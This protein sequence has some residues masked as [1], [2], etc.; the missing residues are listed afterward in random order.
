MNILLSLWR[1]DIFLY[2]CSMVKNNIPFKVAVGYVAVAVVMVMA[3]VLVYG[4][5]QSLLNI[6]KMSRDYN[7]KRNVVDSLVY[8]MLDVSNNER[9]IYM[10]TSKDWKKLR[11][12]IKEAK[13]LTLSLKMLE[14]DSLQRARMDTL[15]SLLSLKQ[16]NLAELRKIMNYDTRENLLNEKMENLNSGKDSVMVHTKT[17]KTH[18]NERTTVEVVKT[19]KGFFRRLADA[20]KKGTTDTISIHNDVNSTTTD[21]VAIPVDVA[22]E[23]VGVLSQINR[24]ERKHSIRKQ[25]AV[26][27]ELG[28]LRIVSQQLAH[29]TTLLLDTIRDNEKRTMQEA[30]VRALKSR[31]SLL[32][33]I[34][35]LALLAIV[36]AGILFLYISRDAKKERIYR[37][38]LENANAEIQRI[39]N[40]R[41]RLLLTI[42]HDIKAPVASISGFIDLMR[43][44]VKD[45][46]AIGYIDN[47]VN[48][49]DHLSRLVASLLDYHKLENGQMELHPTAFSPSA[50]VGQATE[51]MRMLA[52]R[53][54]LSI[55]MSFKD[56][57]AARSESD[58]ASPKHY[59]ADA[60]RIRQVLDN[61]ISNAIKYTQ[62]GEISVNA[63]VSKAPSDGN[64]YLTVSVKDTGMGMTAEESRRAFMAFTRLQNAQGIEGTGLGL[65]ITHELVTLLG[66]K[67]TLKSVKDVGSTFTVTIPVSQATADDNAISGEKA[68]DQAA[69]APFQHS[70]PLTL[71]NQKILILDDDRLQLQLL[72]E[73]LRSKTESGWQVFACQHVTDALTILHNEKPALMLMDIE[74][75]EMS[76]MEIIRMINHSQMK[77]VAMTAHDPSIKAELAKAGFDGCL[78]KPFQP[79]ALESL[80]GPSSAESPQQSCPSAASEHS[81]VYLSELLA[82]A[83]GDKEAEQEILRTVIAE[84]HTYRNSLLC[85]LSSPSD[86]QSP[87][88]DFKQEAGRIAHKLLPIATLLHADCLPQLQSLSPEQI[89][90]LNADAIHECLNKVNNDLASILDAI[91]R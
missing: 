29:R 58:E 13:R 33:Q 56:D 22:D 35:L 70:K 61:L 80:I 43:D 4:N 30:L 63:F 31:Q 2:F 8:S 88:P 41:E 39:M 62:K 83:A 34:S 73:M 19:R 68:D 81:N 64:R 77:V 87:L 84:L 51:G 91:E 16:D 14:Q 11:L 72:Q 1:Q 3:I 48:S 57:A 23:V 79:D 15:V 28:D 54:G 17:A 46:K 24:E 36:A 12:S 32:W 5:T 49:S 26:S 86:E 76:G 78:F 66:G 89:H 42:T 82:F 65:S 53:K 20:F 25:M 50:L 90:N 7:Y 40:Q 75:P 67:I 74:M 38:N 9:S 85:L 44:Y 55:N 21:S 18:E 6:N 52:E 69:S 45:A 71:T 47:I 60:F 10:G 59:V 37:E 27:K